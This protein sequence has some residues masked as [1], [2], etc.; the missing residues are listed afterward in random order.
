MKCILVSLVSSWV[1]LSCLALARADEANQPPTASGAEASAV[2]AARGVLEEALQATQQSLAEADGD[3]RSCA[4]LEA[5]L[6]ALEQARRAAAAGDNATAVVTLKRARE[7]LVAARQAHSRDRSCCKEITPKGCPEVPACGKQDACAI[8][9]V[10]SIDQPPP[11]LTSNGAHAFASIFAAAAARGVENALIRAMNATQV[12][13]ACALEGR[14]QCEHR[15]RAA[16]NPPPSVEQPQP[17]AENG[18]TAT[19]PGSGDTSRADEDSDAAATRIAPANAA[20]EAPLPR[21]HL[22]PRLE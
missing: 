13:P 18:G 17:P 12:C 2:D 7:Q 14:R 4:A 19:E 8:L 21:H 15:G 20:A 16:D 11:S 3:R 5:A 6:E 1:A 10:P 9:R 22:L